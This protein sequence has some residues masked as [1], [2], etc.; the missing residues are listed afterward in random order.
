[1]SETSPQPRKRAP[2]PARAQKSE[3][4]RA[5]LINAA[6]KVIGKHGYAGCS[7][8]RITRRAGVAH[9]AFYLHFKSQQE[10]FDQILPTLGQGM[11]DAISLAVRDSKDIV[12]LE[13]KGLETNFAYIA[14][15]PY[16]YR[17]MNEAELY[18]P[19]AFK[20]HLD[21]MISR[22]SRS[23]HRSL[24]AHQVHDFSPGDLEALAAMLLG[25]RSY[26]LMNFCVEK[27]VVKPLSPELIDRYL[28]FMMHGLGVHQEKGEP[29]RIGS[30]YLGALHAARSPVEA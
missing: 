3:N 12:E 22:Y 6:A 2:S 5:R 23:L 29:T 20:A 17:V 4:T 15:H 28:R 19:K 24:M 30:G 8:A 18:A 1:M 13:R 7:I 11:L 16:M 14:K 21:E 10:L 26:L 25:A 9:G 27:N